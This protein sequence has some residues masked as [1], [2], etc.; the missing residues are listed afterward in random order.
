[1]PHLRRNQSSTLQ[2]NGLQHRRKPSRR[3]TPSHVHTLPCP[4]QLPPLPRFYTPRRSIPFL[5]AVAAL[6]DQGHL[7]NGHRRRISGLRLSKNRLQ[8]Q[9]GSSGIAAHRMGLPAG[10]VVRQYRRGIFF[11]P[12]DDF[13]FSIEAYSKMRSNEG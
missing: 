8:R 5:I 9:M 3:N 7:R 11:S 1:M 10:L 4:P 12:T 6:H 2:R 13:L